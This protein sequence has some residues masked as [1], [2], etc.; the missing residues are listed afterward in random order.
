MVKRDS[1]SIDDLITYLSNKDSIILDYDSKNINDQIFIK[2]LQ[3]WGVC[4]EK[5]V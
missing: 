3:F 1:K 2:N 5:L 4:P